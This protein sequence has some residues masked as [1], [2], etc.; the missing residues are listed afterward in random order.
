MRKALISVKGIKAGILEELGAGRFRFAYLDAYQGSPV[1]LTMPA[2]KKIYEFDSF[3]P[4]FDGLLPEG[5][6]L[7]ALLKR[8]KIDRHDLMGQLVTVGADMVGDVT[9]EEMT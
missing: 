8:H 4:F 3:P 5:F 6:M 2:A 9:A 7:E 1:S